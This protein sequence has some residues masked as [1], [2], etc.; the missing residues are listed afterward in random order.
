MIEGIDEDNGAN[1]EEHETSSFTPSQT[2]YYG[3]PGCGKSHEI[4]KKLKNVPDYNKIRTVFHP[5]YSNADFVGQILPE[6]NIT[7]EG[8]SIIEYKFKPG[9]FTEIVRRAY[10]NPDENFYLVIEEINRGNAA[11]IFGEM[12]QLLDRLD[13]DEKTDEVSSEHIYGKGWSS[14]GVDNQDVN[15]YIRNQVVISQEKTK[16]CSNVTGSA[17]DLNPRLYK[18]MDIE[19]ENVTV[20]WREKNENGF[21]PKSKHIHF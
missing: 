5:E 13:A 1:A 9:P 15:A 4:K 2:I 18:S 3:V 11:A 7:A 10:L 14:Y 6:V 8:R 21:T 19:S 20:T 16:H 12:F 17:G